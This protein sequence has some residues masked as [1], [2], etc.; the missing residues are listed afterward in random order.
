MHQSSAHT[1]KY[2]DTQKDASARVNA[3]MHGG[4]GYRQHTAQLT[5]LA[6]RRKNEPCNAR[7]QK[8]AGTFVTAARIR[9]LL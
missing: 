8:G 1:C 3:E 4:I 5:T 6:R 2:T 9:V 7:K